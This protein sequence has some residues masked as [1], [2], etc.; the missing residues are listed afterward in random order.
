MKKMG[1]V[2]GLLIGIPL[3][4]I[5]INFLFFRGNDPSENEINS[6]ISHSKK[7]MII[8]PQ[9]AKTENKQ[10]IAGLSRR[11]RPSAF[12][13]KY[14]FYD[15]RH[16]KFFALLIFDGFDKKSNDRWWVLGDNEEGDKISVQINQDQ[17][18]DPKYGTENN[19][20]P[21]FPRDIHNLKG[22]FTSDPFHVSDPLNFIFVEQYLKFFMP[23]DEFAKM[24]KQ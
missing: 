8:L 24:F 2:I 21:V 16:K 9:N 6:Y 14:Y 18:N 3:F 13:K 7:E 23:K 15:S 11:G 19:P 20:V 17:L 10:Y 4:I 1:F 22:G 12:L 5:L